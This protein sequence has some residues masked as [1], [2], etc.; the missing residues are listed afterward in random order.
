MK[1]IPKSFLLGL[2]VLI[3]PA[4]SCSG[5]N[6]NLILQDKTLEGPANLSKKELSATIDIY[7][8]DYGVILSDESSVFQELER[9]KGESYKNHKS[10][11]QVV[12]INL[13]QNQVVVSYGIDDL[14]KE[15]SLTQKEFLVTF[16]NQAANVG[17]L[18]VSNIVEKYQEKLK[19]SKMSQSEK[20][21]IRT[22]LDTSELAL[23]AIDEMA[24]RGL[25]QKSDPYWD[26]V[27]E[28][29]GVY[30]AR[31]MVE[32]TVAGGIQGGLAGASGGTIVLPG[33][34]TAGG[35]TNGAVF[36]AARGAVVGAMGGAFW[37][38]ADC[39]RFLDNG[40]GGG[41]GCATERVQ[42]GN[43]GMI[44]SVCAAQENH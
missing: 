31:G 40:S 39:L 9:I 15:Y 41:S 10:Y 43:H 34:G 21:V 1:R 36:G 14:S 16:Y 6:E 29:L 33:V 37:A 11:N 18:E 44:F 8:K 2:L 28:K 4:F 12:Q 32:G 30:V 38:A 7:K 26:C 27:Q 42:T 17:F 13:K 3:S 23:Q 35:A 19:L 5:D 24:E 22:I 20:D 25:S